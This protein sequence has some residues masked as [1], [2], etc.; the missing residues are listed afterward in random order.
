MLVGDPKQ[1]PSIEAGG[2][3]A[4]LA[5]E[6]QAVRLTGNQRQADPADRQALRDYR[7]RDIGAALASSYRARGRL[8]IHPNATQQKA[9]M[10]TAWWT[11]QLKGV[12]S[13]MLAYRRRG[14]RRPQRPYPPAHD[15][16]GQSQRARNRG[17]RDEQL[18]ERFFK[19]GDHVLLRR[20]DYPLG[21]RNGQRGQV[22]GDRMEA[23]ATRSFISE[24]G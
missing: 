3:F 20:N 13:V 15:R 9:A 5:A 2:L 7:D 22:Q 4:L 18:G 17:G 10:I 19:S 16:R 1:L 14:I 8:R 24:R 23:R 12:P 11:G 6:L 21:V